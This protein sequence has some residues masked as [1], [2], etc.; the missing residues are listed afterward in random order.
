MMLDIGRCV[1]AEKV[2]TQDQMDVYRLKQVCVLLV[3][4]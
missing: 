3:D 2:Q 4:F 1:V